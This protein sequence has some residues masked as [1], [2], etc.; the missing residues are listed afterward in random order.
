MAS[1]SNPVLSQNIV[2]RYQ[3]NEQYQAKILA[4]L[5]RYP[6]F[7]HRYGEVV[8]PEFFEF[9]DMQIVARQI[10]DFYKRYAVVPTR[11]SFFAWI[12]D[13]EVKCHIPPAVVEKL[14]QLV[15]MIFSCDMSD[16]DAVR[17][18]AIEFA[19]RQALKRAIMDIVAKLEKFDDSYETAQVAVQNALLVGQGLGSLGTE[20]FGMIPRLPGLVAMDS[21]YST[22]RKIATPFAKL[23]AARMGGI[24]PGELMIIAGSSGQGKSII[25]NNCGVLATMQAQGQWV[26][27]ATLELSELDNHLRYGARILNL[28]MDDIVTNSPDFVQA[29]SRLSAE[30]RIYVKWF[31]PG[32]TTV[33]HL[34]SWISALSSELGVT[35]CMIIVDYPDLMVPSKGETDSLYINNAKISNEIIALLNDYQA[36]GVVSSQIDRFH[37]N[38]GDARANNMANSIAKLYNADI[39]GTINQTEEDK[40]NGVGR[41]W[42]DKVRRG[43]SAFYSYYRIDYARSTVMEDDEVANLVQQG[44]QTGR[45]NGR[46]EHAAQAPQM[47]PAPAAFAPPPLLSNG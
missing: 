8:R 35:P 36:A 34:R 26:A 45:N 44:R 21:P 5:V 41:I 47:Q 9:D 25:K 28:P 14:S 43:R 6:Q 27:H 16:G 33:G 17:D 15:A 39:V 18:T 37:Q 11:E 30:S 7:I 31:P 23:N 38:S 20:V 10:L 22:A 29:C 12:H 4:L 19:K 32:Q 1:P 46:Q 2:Q 40:V 3:Y 42:W 24:G 13:Y